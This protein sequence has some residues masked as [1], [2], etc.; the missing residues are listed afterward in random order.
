[1][2]KNPIYQPGKPLKKLILGS[3]SPRRKELLKMLDVPFSVR[4]IDVAEDFPLDLPHSSVPAFL[5]KKKGLAFLPTMATDELVI[6][7]DTVVLAKGQI[8]NK[9]AT[10]QEAKEMLSLL[11]GSKHMV[12]TAVYLIDHDK[13]VLIE[14]VAWVYF[15]PLSP[16]E[17][18]YYV[19]KYKPFDKAGGYG[20]QEWIGYV[21]I[22]KIEGSFYTVMGLP[23]HRLYKELSQW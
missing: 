18:A 21:A 8:L 11:S 6:T 10:T 19:E 5:A 2:A 7:A 16:S 22:E 17:V 1:M 12:V 3:Q 14:D 20:I 23:V 4:Q 13:Q 15:N 9:P